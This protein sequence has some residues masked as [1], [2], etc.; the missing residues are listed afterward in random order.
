MFSLEVDGKTYC[1]PEV[2]ESEDLDRAYQ[3]FAD[4]LV[5]ILESLPKGTLAGWDL[6][7]KLARI[8]LELVPKEV[9]EHDESNILT[10]FTGEKHA[11]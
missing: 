10:F 9:P 7:K 11:V 8:H 5:I 6:R 3:A 4:I 2:L 1:F